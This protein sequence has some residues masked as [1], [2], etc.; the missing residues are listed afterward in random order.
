MTDRLMLDV[1]DASRRLAAAPGFTAAA[2]A[3]LALGIGSS[4]A[5]FSAVDTFALRG[6]GFA[7]PAELVNI[8]QDSDDGRPESN[9][10]PTYV[11]VSQHTDLFSGVGAV[12]PEGSGTLLTES[13]DAEVVQVEFATSTY[14][15]VLGLQP[16]LGRWFA[17]EEDR[18]GAP[19]SAVL[20]H[21][22][23]RRRFASNPSVIGRTVRVSGASVTIVGVGPESH[24]GFISGLASDFWMSISAL[25]PVGGAFRGATLTR[26]DD[27]WFQ[28]V[29][30]L[31]PGRTV[32]EAQAAMTVLAERVGREFPDSDRGRKMTVMSGTDVRI[33]P[34]IDAMIYPTAGLNLLLTALLLIV[35]CSNLAN[36]M[37][38]RGSTR[39]R[40]LA[41]RLAIGATRGQIVRS[42]VVESLLLSVAGGA[43]GLA[44][45]WWAVAV[46]D[47]VE[48]PLQFPVKAFLSLDY[49]VAGFAIGISLLCGLAFGLL[50]AIR[51]SRRDLAHTLKMESRAARS[52]LRIVDLRGLLV[53]LQLAISL[54]LIVCGG[55]LL[56]SMLNAMHVDLGFDPASVVAVTIDP[57]Q[58]G[59]TSQQSLQ[60]LTDLRERAASHPGVETAALATRPP[61]S[62]FGPSNTIVLDEHAIHRTES[63]TVDV[64]AAGVTPEYFTALRIHLLHGRDFTSAD[65]AG[66]ERVAIVS[67]AMARRFWGTSNVVGRRYRHGGGDTPWIT[68]V[69][70]AQDVAIVSPGETPRAFIYRPLAQGGYGRAALIVRGRA[71]P[72]ALIGAIRQ[73][74]RALDPL[75]PLLQPAS[76]QGHIDRALAAPRIASRLLMALGAMAVL[77]ACAGIYSVVAF[78]VARRRNEMGVRMALG[79]TAPQVVRL[80]VSEMA[81]LVIIGVA[82]GIALG[83]LIAPALRSLLIGIQPLD[84][85]TF[86]AAAA[87]VA[88]VALVTAW[89]PARRAADSNPATVLRAE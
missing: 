4:T 89:L 79:A 87:A 80:V 41:V 72:E 77:L 52:A 63:G 88:V 62:P 40:E 10:Y 20:T 74:V 68:I 22:A 8:Y 16:R 57:M 6:R 35:V 66:A 67:E 1:R 11:D 9:S 7:R 12:M 31:A 78:S 24:N 43:I 45:A 28:I 51:N 70:V 48:I 75:I 23:W 83:A 3:M 38:A 33:H 56:R 85:R 69:G 64:A 46:I 65:R 13:G 76:M 19:A 73:E 53:V 60:V 5:I 58:A 37:L 15:P 32:P 86:A 26:R 14:F 17:P 71:E 49:R 2:L 25:G 27:H 29:A 81:K 34:E 47:S 82:A 55:V 44:L 18:P 36:L 54:A 50:P 84:A 61:M 59:R 39:T 21:A 42:L 30:R